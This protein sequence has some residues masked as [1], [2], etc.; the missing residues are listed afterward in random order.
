MSHRH[1][2]KFGVQRTFHSI[3]SSSARGCSDSLW[4]SFPLLAVPLLSY[5]PVHPPDLHLIFFMTWLTS[6]LRTLTDKDLGTLSEYDPLTAF[7]DCAL[8]SSPGR[9]PVWKHRPI[10]DNWAEVCGFLKPS[11]SQKCWKVNKH[12][13]LVYVPPTKAWLHLDFVD[14]SKTHEPRISLEERPADGGYDNPKRRI[15]EVMSDQPFALVVTVVT[16]HMWCSLCV[17]EGFV[18]RLHLLGEVH[19]WSYCVTSVKLKVEGTAW[20]W[21]GMRGGRWWWWRG[22]GNLTKRSY[23]AWMR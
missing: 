21:W 8:S 4:L 9:T 13:P 23:H 19:K 20:G 11:G 22:Q 2:L 10:P 7:T 5:R 3:P 1:W 12:G 14:W 18:S 6:T 17:G 15:S 16:I